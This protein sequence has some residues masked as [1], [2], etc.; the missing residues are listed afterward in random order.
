LIGTLCYELNASTPFLVAVMSKA[1]KSRRVSKVVTQSLTLPLDD[2]KLIDILK[3][4][5]G[6]MTSTRL[7]FARFLKVGASL[8]AA[9]SH[10]TSAKKRCSNTQP[11]TQEIKQKT[12]IGSA[13]TLHGSVITAMPMQ[14]AASR[15]LAQAAPA[16][17]SLTRVLHAIDFVAHARPLHIRSDQPRTRVRLCQQQK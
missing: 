2:I 16:N 6:F 3:L 4:E 9:A 7:R 14:N 1:T 8:P 5:L 12:K 15:P 13:R 11:F 17:A 10:T